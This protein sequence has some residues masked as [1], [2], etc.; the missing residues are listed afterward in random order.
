MSAKEQGKE[1]FN[2]M[3]NLF[4][5]TTHHVNE[6]ALKNMAHDLKTLYN[7][8][9]DEGFKDVQAMHIIDTILTG[10]MMSR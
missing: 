8:L 4:M 1:N 3:L 7:S 6:D 5:Q 9:R 2:N 10:G